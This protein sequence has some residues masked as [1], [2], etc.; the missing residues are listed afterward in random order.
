[1]VYCA[2]KAKER[3]RKNKMKQFVSAMFM[4]MAGAVFADTVYITLVTT[5][6]AV[7]NEYLNDLQSVVTLDDLFTE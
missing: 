3:N 7:R 4:L 1:M 2:H 6:G 5:C